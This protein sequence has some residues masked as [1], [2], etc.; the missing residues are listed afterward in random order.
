MKTKR[1]IILDP[2]VPDNMS[3]ENIRRLENRHVVEKEIAENPIYPPK[4]LKQIESLSI[5]EQQTAH[6]ESR[7]VPTNDSSKYYLA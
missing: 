3:L 6:F 2:Q 7:L 1:N 5:N 4:F